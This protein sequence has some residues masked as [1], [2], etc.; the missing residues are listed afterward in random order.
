[1]G[2][3]EVVVESSSRLTESRELENDPSALVA[4]EYA[5]GDSTAELLWEAEGSGDGSSALV[6]LE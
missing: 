2:D 6:G 4:L 5:G 1:V 3:R